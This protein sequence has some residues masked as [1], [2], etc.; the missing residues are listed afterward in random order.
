[1]STFL[2]QYHDVNPQVEGAQA[3]SYFW[4]LMTA[5][6]LVGMILLKLIDSK[7]LLQISGV[8]T[9]VLLITALF[10]NKEASIIAFPA[11][12]FS[13]SM[14]YSIVFSLAL[15]SAYSTSWFVRRYSVFGYCRRSRWP[16]DYQY[17]GRC[18]LLA[19][20]YADYTYICR[21]YHFHRLL[22]ASVNQQQDSLP[23]RAF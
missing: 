8:L 22:G 13:I 16:D 18:H 10:G 3:V 6:C 2:E 7:R 14:M 19:H 20:R 9:I 5:G 4:G 21:L 11:I 15:N 23:E 12:G 17:A 1:M